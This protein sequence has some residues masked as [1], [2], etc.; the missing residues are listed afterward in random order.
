MGVNVVVDVTGGAAFDFSLAL[1]RVI[2]LGITTERLLTT[3]DG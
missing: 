1:V 2:A 3:T